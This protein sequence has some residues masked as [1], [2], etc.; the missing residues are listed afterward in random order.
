MSGPSQVKAVPITHRRQL[1]EYVAEGAKPKAQWR[2]GTEHEKFVFRADDLRRAPY[3]GA[4]GI[5]ALLLALTR[6]GWQQVKEGE[7]V[8]ALVKDGASVTLE[9]G[10]QFELS[11]APLRS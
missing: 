10:G 7:N 4:S 9:P 2:I 1:V 11:G 3:E 5:R 6:Y 8:I